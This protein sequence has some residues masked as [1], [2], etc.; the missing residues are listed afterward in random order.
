MHN[1]FKDKLQLHRRCSVK[2][3]FFNI[4]QNSEEKTCAGVSLILETFLKS[5]SSTVVSLWILQIF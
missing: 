1:F 3:M 4:S 2:K 5:D